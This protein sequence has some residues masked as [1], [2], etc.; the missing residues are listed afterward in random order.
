MRFMAEHAAWFR[1]LDVERT[2]AEVHEV[3]R[4]GADV[5]LDD[6]RRLVEEGQAT[7]DIHDADPGLLAVGVLGAVS[8]YSSWI[9]RAQSDDR[10][11]IDEV[12]SF[13]RAWV[14][15]ALA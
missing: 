9:R 8:S 12:A 15:G 4:E 13:V 10:P 1:L 2:D 14:A 11:D 7:G 6:V 5:Y 3:V